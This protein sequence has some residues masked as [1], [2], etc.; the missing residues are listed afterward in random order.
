MDDKTKGMVSEQ[1]NRAYEQLVYGEWIPLIVG[2]ITFFYWSQTFNGFLAPIVPLLGL[3][4]AIA[5]GYRIGRRKWEVKDGNVVSFDEWASATSDDRSTGSSDENES[6]IHE[7]VRDQRQSTPNG[8]EYVHESQQSHTGTA[9][10]A[11]VLLLF[12]GIIIAGLGVGMSETTQVDKTVCVEE[13]YD[14]ECVEESSVEYSE[15]EQDPM[16]P[17]AIGIGGIM[18]VGAVVIYGMQ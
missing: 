17:V 11:I 1:A 5:G 8:N 14:G 3:V 7:S 15:S 18:I 10:V 13:N 16:K 9:G 2:G 6:P 12:I 4:I